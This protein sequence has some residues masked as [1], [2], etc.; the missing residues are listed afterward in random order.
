MT[1][2]EMAATEIAGQHGCGMNDPC[3]ECVKT[4]ML[5]MHRIALAIHVERSETPVVDSY[6]SGI[7]RARAI[8]LD[9]QDL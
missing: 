3:R 5:I 4:A 1:L 7:I 6:Y 9:G 8:V 2:T